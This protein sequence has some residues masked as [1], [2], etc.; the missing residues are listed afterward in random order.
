[1][2]VSICWFAPVAMSSDAEND[3]SVAAPAVRAV[4]TTGAGDVLVGVVAARLAQGWGLVPATEDA[5]AIATRAVTSE[6]ARG[7]L[8]DPD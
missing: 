3:Q 2:Q 1:M 8:D 7:Y 4:D 5:C 6:G